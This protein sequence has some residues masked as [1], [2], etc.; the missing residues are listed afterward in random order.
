MM[1]NFLLWHPTKVPKLVWLKILQSAS[2]N[3]WHTGLNRCFSS[4][5]FHT[6]CLKMVILVHVGMLAAHLRSVL[7]CTFSH[8]ADALIQSKY[9]DIPPEGSRVKC[10]DTTSFCTAGN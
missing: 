1:R 2:L 5:C 10:Q 4:F 9:R 7:T 8:L 6:R 3:K